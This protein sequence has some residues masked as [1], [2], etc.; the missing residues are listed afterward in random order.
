M[1]TQ[2]LYIEHNDISEA[3]VKMCNSYQNNGFVRMLSTTGYELQFQFR[4]K[5][6]LC[7]IPTDKITNGKL[8]VND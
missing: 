7:D 8:L 4:C 2:W 1:L 6:W 5:D 3:V